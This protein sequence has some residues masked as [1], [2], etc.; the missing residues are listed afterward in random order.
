[1]R[2]SGD[3]AVGCDDIF[4]VGGLSHVTVVC[5]RTK[6]NVSLLYPAVFARRLDHNAGEI[7]PVDPWVARLAKA[8]V[9]TFPVDRVES[10]GEGLHE[11]LVVAAEFWDPLGFLECILLAGPVK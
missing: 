8:I 1:M 9:C 2:D 10:D 3:V 11:D 7:T 6:D 5:R 4:L